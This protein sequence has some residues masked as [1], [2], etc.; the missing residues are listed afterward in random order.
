[1]SSETS[2]MC[3]RLSKVEARWRKT[4]ILEE[5]TV[6]NLITAIKLQVQK[7]HITPSTTNRKVT[8]PSPSSSNCSTPGMKRKSPTRKKTF[9]PEKQH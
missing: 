2:N 3:N 6:P 7:A 1:M 8:I 5:I 9:Y 4:K